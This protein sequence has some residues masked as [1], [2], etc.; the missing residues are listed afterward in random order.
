MNKKQWIA[1]GVAGVAGALLLTSLSHRGHRG[2]PHVAHA[3]AGHAHVAHAYG[4][5]AHTRP[6]NGS[7]RLSVKKDGKSFGYSSNRRGVSLRFSDRDRGT[8]IR[9]R[10]GNDNSYNCNERFPR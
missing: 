4:G 2:C 6:Y 8:R 7:V 1:T 10:V 3:P 9:G 5:H